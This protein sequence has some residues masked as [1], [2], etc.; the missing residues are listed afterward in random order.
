MV[1]SYSL[2][3]SNNFYLNKFDLTVMS[4]TLNIIKYNVNTNAN[5]NANGVG[6]IYLAQFKNCT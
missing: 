1:T 3:S 4:G 2:S 5:A 6:E